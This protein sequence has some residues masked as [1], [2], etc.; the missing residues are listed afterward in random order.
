MT[1]KLWILLAAVMLAFTDIAMP[2]V[3]QSG[4]ASTAQRARSTRN[5]DSVDIK[6]A[7]KALKHNGHDPGLIDEVI[8][9]HTSAAPMAYQKE[10]GL[11]VTGRLDDATLAKLEARSA[12]DARL[13]SGSS[14]SQPT[15]DT[16][17]SAVDPADAHKSG[18]NVGEGA[19]YNRSTE[20]GQSTMKGANQQK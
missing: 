17:P 1:M 15:G 2:V 11:S 13:R 5:G 8:G 20:K 6:E 3:A 18:A 12:S 9:P 10:Q 19:S 14:G 4:G 7:Q 16:R